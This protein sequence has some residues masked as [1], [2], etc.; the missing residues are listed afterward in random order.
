MIVKFAIG[1]GG[2]AYTIYQNIGSELPGMGKP[3]EMKNLTEEI[4]ELKDNLRDQEVKL[5]EAQE[6]LSN[7][8]ISVEQFDVM[9]RSINNQRDDWNAQMLDLRNTRNR[10]RRNTYYQGALIFVVLGGFLATFLTSGSL[11]EAGKPNVQTILSTVVV[12]AGWSGILSK[13]LQDGALK[14]ESNEIKLKIDEIEANYEKIIRDKVNET[15]KKAN[16]EIK[17]ISEGY[18]Q[19]VKELREKAEKGVEFIEK[20]NKLK[21]A[22]KGNPT[23]MDELAKL[24]YEFPEV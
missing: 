23:I 5:R 2:A 20:I 18:E 21:E 9:E 12:G 14:E 16:D 4:D 7:K 19:I 11:I 6:K 24:R 15:T 3:T 17:S 13:Y 22:V 1:C 10:L 8:E